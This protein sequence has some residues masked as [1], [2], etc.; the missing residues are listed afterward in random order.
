MEGEDGGELVCLVC[1]ED[2]HRSHQVCEL[3]PCTYV[4]LHVYKGGP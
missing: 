3:R 1:L 2:I 4:F